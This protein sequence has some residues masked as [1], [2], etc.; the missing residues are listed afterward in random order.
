M[1][2]GFGRID[3]RKNILTRHVLVY[4]PVDC[5]NL[6]DNFFQAAMQVFRIHT[7]FHKRILLYRKGYMLIIIFG[8]ALV[9]RII[10]I[11]SGETNFSTR[12]IILHI[13]YWAT[14]QA[15]ARPRRKVGV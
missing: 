7:L 9:N 5:L 14:I 13:M 12:Y 6:P 3:L 8:T 10:F 4:H 15:A 11:V 1:Q 2:R